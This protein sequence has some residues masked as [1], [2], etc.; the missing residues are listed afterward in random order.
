MSNGEQYDVCVIGSGPAGSTA[1]TFV[2]MRGHRVLLIEKEA[3]PLYKIGE[4]LL[5]ATVHGIC[6]MLG[7]TEELKR[8]NFV[9]K[10]GGT[11]RWGRNKEPWTF[12]FAESSK[13]QGPT[14]YAYQVE[15]IKF[16]AILLNNAKRKGVEV[17]EQHT[18]Q[19]LLFEEDRVCGVKLLDDSGREE[20]IRSRYVV[21]ASGHTSSV[22]RHAGQ[23]IYSKFFRN[24]A[25]FAYFR[26]ADRL[27]GANSGNI[28]CAAFEKGWFWFIPLSKTLTSVGAVVG[29]E[30]SSLFHRGHEEALAELIA[31]CAPIQ[32]L[33]SKAVRCNDAPYDQIS[34]RKDYSYCHSS[35]WRPGLVLIGDAACFIDPVFSSGVHLATYSALLAARSINTRLANCLNDE[36]AFQEFEARYRRE[37]RCFYDFLT[38]FYDLDQDLESYYWSARVMMNSQEQGNHAFLSLVGGDASGELSHTCEVDKGKRGLDSK[39]IFPAAAGM[40][41]D[42]YV[43]SGHQSTERKRFWNELN[44]EGFQLQLRAVLKSSAPPEQPMFRNGLV[45]S[46]D[47]LHW[48]QPAAMA[49]SRV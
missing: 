36:A 4:S 5:P 17:R 13:F 49:V 28:F 1:A 9:R 3:L 25:V 15:R 32:S 22:A 16:D 18:V 30:H 8:Q 39:Q 7:V 38:A 20:T 34:I 33:L 35:F 21:D 44:T 43:E 6:G 40:S 31:S 11:F 12:A 26:N 46:A 14:S 48:L 2:A 29:E 10:L 37:Y 24:I 27:P 23:R 19:D 47:G 45:P 41:A 42:M